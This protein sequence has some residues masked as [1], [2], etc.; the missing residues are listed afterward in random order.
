MSAGLGVPELAKLANGG[1][2]YA[3]KRKVS[4]FRCLH[5][6]PSRTHSRDRDLCCAVD[7]DPASSAVHTQ[8]EG[9]Y[10]TE[11]KLPKS[12]AAKEWGCQG[13]KLPRGEA[14]KE[15]SCQGVK[16]PRSKAILFCSAATKTRLVDCILK[17][18]RDFERVLICPG[19]Y[20][21][22]VKWREVK[23]LWGHCSEPH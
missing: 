5:I 11:V 14:A 23:R 22:N 2:A 21:Q 16:L 15:W 1:R 18:D 12:E 19:N 3:V 8:N 6:P 17:Y 20:F 7:R 9:Q 13:V 4:S 10:K